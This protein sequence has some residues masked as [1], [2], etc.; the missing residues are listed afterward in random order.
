M[1][2]NNTKSTI[3]IGLI[4]TQLIFIITF[5]QAQD[6]HFS[7]FYNT[8]L[9]QNPA[10]TGKFKGDYRLGGA[11]RNQWK[12]INATFA[13]TGLF[14]DM[15]FRL[16][17]NNPNKIGLGLLII[18][19][20][21]GDEQYKNQYFQVS[22][23]YHK[24]IDRLKRHKISSG[25][26]IGYVR[27]NL[28]TDNLT[29]SSQYN[30]WQLTN[31]PSGEIL[32]ADAIGYINFNAGLFWD[33]VVNNR[34]DCY[35][36]I[37]FYNLTKPKETLYNTGKN[38]QGIRKNFVIGANYML[39]KNI[40][41]LPSIQITNQLKAFDIN[42]GGA[43]GYSIVSGKLNQSTL[44]IGTWYRAKDAMII[45][46]G[47]KYKNNQLGLSYDITSSD[48]NDIKNAPNIGRSKNIGAFEITFIHI[49]FLNRALPNDLTVPCRFF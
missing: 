3:I 43:I 23:A 16:G 39:S 20:E 34:F 13:T 28:N 18:N 24:I 25:L 45:Y 42:L 46:G 37:S 10:L 27:K 47:I 33:F 44:M 26:Q 22:T 17:I 15:N 35:A 4:F 11:Y 2:E 30:G 49:G 9:S 6:Y 41:L 40:S 36:G 48:L 12:Q 1:K 32:N 5:A 29:F 19:D 14:A 21:L 8:P 38:E 31:N 7:Q